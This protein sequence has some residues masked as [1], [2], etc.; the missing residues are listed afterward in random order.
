MPIRASSRTIPPPWPIAL[1]VGLIALFVFSMARPSTGQAQ[2]APVVDQQQTLI[3]ATVGGL[4]IGGGSDQ[5]LAQVFTPAVS[6]ALTEVRLAVGCTGADLVVEIQGASSLGGIGG[7]PNGSV[8]GSQTF[9]GATLDGFPAAL[10]SLPLAAPV[11]LAAGLP[12]A[13]VLRAANQTSSFSSCASYQATPGDTYSGGNMYFI[14]APNSPTAWICN[15]EF[16]PT[17]PL[18]L[19]FQTVVEPGPTP[20]EM[21]TLTPSPTRTPVPTATATATSRPSATPTR[22]PGP[23]A[24]PSAQDRIDQLKS[25]VR[26]ASTTG[27]LTNTGIAT[28]LIQKLD[29]ARASLSRGSAG[30][31]TACYQ[32]NAFARQ[33]IALPRGVISPALKQGLLANTEQTMRQIG[34]R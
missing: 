9:A 29:A 6:G 5:K 14:A 8:L 21:P 12:Y 2:A 10:R 32:L 34:C 31:T 33:L 27:T 13:I 20:S 26:L 7:G 4:A 1:A 22:K 19:P 25:S 23:T 17:V 11:Q 30:T 16:G 28:A 3:D 15:C 18:D 24:T